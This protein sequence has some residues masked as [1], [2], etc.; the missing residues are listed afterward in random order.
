[1][2]VLDKIMARPGYYG[3]ITGVSIGVGFGTYFLA[4]FIKKKV[5]EMREK[6]EKEEYSEYVD[7]TEEYDTVDEWPDIPDGVNPMPERVIGPEFAKPSL[8]EMVDYT[9]FYSNVPEG[10]SGEEEL[11][12]SEKGDDEEDLDNPSFVII[13]EQEY[14][15][16]S[17]GTVKADGT[18]FTQDKLLA[19]WNESLAEKDISSTIGWKAVHAF[20]DPAVRSV[21]VRNLDLMV[22]YEIVRC[23]DP[24]EDVLQE[25]LRSEE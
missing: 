20:D 12:E 4:G 24:F 17:A 21:Y 8:A 18:Y 19:G 11:E 5:C 10:E 14:M 6:S 23:D 7:K 25:T 3:A 9:K 1:M 16:T 22:D 2:V 13:S 15:N